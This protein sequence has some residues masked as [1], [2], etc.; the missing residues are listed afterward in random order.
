MSESIGRR[1]AVLFGAAA[2]AAAG[3]A[4]IGTMASSPSSAGA[5]ETSQVSGKDGGAITLPLGEAT[6]A[7]EYVLLPYQHYRT[8]GADE[9]YNAA[10]MFEFSNSGF[11]KYQVAFT[12]CT[13]RDASLNYRSVMYVEMSNNAESADLAKLRWVTFGS[14]GDMN[15]GFWGDSNPAPT[16]PDATAEYMDEHL[17]QPLIGLTKADLDAWE[18]YGTLPAG[19]DVDAVS[20]ATVSSSNIV[21]VLQ[22]LFDYHVQKYYTA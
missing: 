13:C 6:Q 21:S 17:I 8:G 16:N 5:S 14:D 12:S 20:G 4:T 22:V 15:V 18:G 19:I 1:E 9:V 11:T 7:G 3:A 2:L 10:I